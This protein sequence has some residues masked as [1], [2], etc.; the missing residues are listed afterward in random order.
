MYFGDGD[1]GYD[2][3]EELQDDDD[4]DDTEELQDEA[5]SSVPAADITDKNLRVD[6]ASL[7]QA[8]ENLWQQVQPAGGV[9]TLRTCGDG[10]CS[11]HAVLGTPNDFRELYY[12]PMLEVG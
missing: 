3:R 6:M 11:V 8:H 5:P 10:A 7:E 2:D 9:A 4:N 1:D 12:M